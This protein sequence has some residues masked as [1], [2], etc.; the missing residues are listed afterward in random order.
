MQKNTERERERKREEEGQTDRLTEI[1]R[2]CQRDI[3]RLRQKY[4]HTRSNKDLN[5]HF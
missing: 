1:E 5:F 4:K 2:D 3:V